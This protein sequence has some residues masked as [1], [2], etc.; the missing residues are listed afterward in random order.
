MC[1]HYLGRGVKYTKTVFVLVIYPL[2]TPLCRIY[3]SMNRSAL[4]QIMACRLLGAKPSLNQCW[5][6][7][8]WTLGNKL[9]W[10][11]IQIQNFSFTKIHL[12]IL[13]EKWRTFRQGWGWVNT[14]PVVRVEAEG[15]QLGYYV[16]RGHGDMSTKYNWS[17]ADVMVSIERWHKH[18]TA[19]YW[20]H[21][22]CRMTLEIQFRI[23]T[24]MQCFKPTKLSIVLH[25]I[26]NYNLKNIIYIILYIIIKNIGK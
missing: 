15:A 12:K 17:S 8:N 13:S 22:V 2:Y 9:Q 14:Q 21:H 24:A 23:N 26:W 25:A 7:V 4:V 20:N 18:M 6:I 5:V 19:L 3:A 10:N 11:F 1:R 16:A